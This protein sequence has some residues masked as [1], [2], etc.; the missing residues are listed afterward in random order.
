MKSIRHQ[1]LCSLFFTIALTASISGVLIYPSIKREIDELYDAHLQQIATL[2]ARQLST[3]DESLLSLADHSSSRPSRW[4]EESYLIQLWDKEGHLRDTELPVSGATAVIVPMQKH[5]GFNHMRLAGQRWQ[6]F[7]ADSARVVV[8]IAQPESARHILIAEISLKL[9][10]TL[11]LQLPVLAVLIWVAVRWGLR[12]LNSLSHAIAQRQPEALSPIT[13]DPDVEE[14]GPL[15]DTL[16]HLFQRLAYVLEQQ[17]NFVADAAHELRTPVATLQLQL[18]LLERTSISPDQKRSITGLRKGIQRTIHLVQ[19]L[20][21]IAHVEAK[22]VDR[23]TQRVDLH[24]AGTLAIERHLPLAQNHQ[25]ELSATQLESIPIRCLDADIDTI[26]DNLLSNA[27]RY[28]PAGGRV[29]LAIYQI[30]NEVVIEV[31][32]TGSGIPESERVRIFDRFYRILRSSTTEIS[33]GSGLGLAI[34][35]TICDRYGATISVGTGHGGIGSRFILRWP[36]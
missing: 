8:Q 12:P 11:M 14:L 25:I 15:V 21:E 2:L 20:L 6:I 9:L 19:Q 13:I 24:A 26:L 33:E 34:I 5:V 35:K 31:V 22:S 17:R 4:E 3:V 23:M 29:D 16:N 28:T 32:D 7:R 18:D 1:L 36:V 10:V 30:Q 27:I